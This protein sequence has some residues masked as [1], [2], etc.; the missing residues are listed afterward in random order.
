MRHRRIEGDVHRIISSRFPPVNVFDGLVAVEALDDLFEVE[1]LTNARLRE[2][3]GELHLIPV[4]DRRVGL[5]WGPIMAAFCHPNLEGSRFSA[6][7]YG[8]YYAGT[9][10][11]TALLES[12]HAKE[13]FLRKAERQPPA[14]FDMRRYVNQVSEQLVEIPVRD[15]PAILDPN[16]YG[17]SSAFGAQ[18]REAGEWGIVYPSVRDA[19][20]T[21]VAV[22]RPPAMT[23]ARQASHYRY[24]WNG[25]RIT[26]YEPLN[27]AFEILPP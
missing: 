4:A 19:G 22:F 17:A 18:L 16:A 25:E 24:H 12:V 1:S 13:R 9:S 2:E 20:G 14:T 6:G 21:C 11:Q 26:H 7:S 5:G 27:A 23:P 10:E 3:L 8:V 15:R